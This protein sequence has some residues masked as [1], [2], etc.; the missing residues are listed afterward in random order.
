MRT[1]TIACWVV[2]TSLQCCLGQLD[3]NILSV[4]EWS[5]PVTDAI[6][7]LR[8]R[9]LIYGPE[10][11]KEKQGT[12]L[13]VYLDLQHVPVP[14]GNKLSMGVFTEYSTA[15]FFEIRDG[16]GKPAEERVILASERP[17]HPFSATLPPDST[18]RLRVP[19]MGARIERDGLLIWGGGTRGWL[20]RSGDIHD[21]YLSGTLSLPRTNQSDLDYHIWQGTLRLPKVRIPVKKL[22]KR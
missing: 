5:A 3:S 1:Q 19:C 4:G 22:M 12:G 17:P 13:R 14:Y 2:A 10:S 16:H 7:P 6:W 18:L 20:I 21:Y 11:E 8:G 9:L 15:I